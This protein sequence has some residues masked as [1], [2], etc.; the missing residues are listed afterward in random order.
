MFSS[1]R[2]TVRHFHFQEISPKKFMPRN[3]GDKFSFWHK[4]FRVLGE[5]STS[6]TW[7]WNKLFQAKRRLKIGVFI[8]VQGDFPP[9]KCP[10]C[11]IMETSKRSHCFREDKA[12]IQKRSE[13]GKRPKKK[14][15]KQQYSFFWKTNS[16]IWRSDGNYS[17]LAACLTPFMWLSESLCFFIAFTCAQVSFVDLAGKFFNATR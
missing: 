16:F 1:R 3:D 13:E 12:G 7:I 2:G 5:Q 15:K 11:K 17:L 8:I 9:N 4:P 6:S 10:P 14:K